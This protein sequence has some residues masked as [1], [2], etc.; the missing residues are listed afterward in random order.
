MPL[1]AVIT[2]DIVDSTSLTKT[3]FKRL[4]KSFESI[5]S[6][7]QYEFFRGDSFQVYVK[8]PQEALTVVL[9]MRTIAMKASR[10]NIVCD[11]K[12]CI[13]IGQVKSTVKS[14][15]TSTG[16]AFV[17]SGRNFDTIKPPQRLLIVCSDNNA[18]V[19]TGL[20]ITGDYI[21]YIFRHLTV[22]QAAVM[23]ELLQS[24]T[25]ADVAKR[26]KKSQATINKHAQSA[27]WPEIEKLSANYKQLIS[28]IKI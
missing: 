19:Q 17:L 6:V 9:R 11:I 15:R 21:D 16:E 26:L 13:G 4:I 18:I 22:K 3:E 14:L 5:L 25:Q 12:A 20:Q 10:E 8:S 2:G 24:R 28:D 23:F 7:H 27:G 1:R